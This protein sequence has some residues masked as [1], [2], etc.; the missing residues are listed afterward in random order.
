MAANKSLIRVLAAFVF[1]GAFLLFSMEPMVGR[2]LVPAFGSA[3][4]V[5]S[6]I[7]MWFQ[8]TL[9]L[10]YLYAHYAAT[11]FRKLH[12]V[13]L[14]LP[15]AVLPF[16][17]PETSQEFSIPAMLIALTQHF[18]LPFFVL[19]TTSV[20]AQKWLAATSDEDPYPLYA[21]SNAGSLLALLAY[22]FAVEPFV[23]QQNQSLGWAVAFGVYVALGVGAWHV[24]RPRAASPVVADAN[25]QTKGRT[26]EADPGEEE[27][28]APRLG[29][30]AYW[31]AVAAAP[32]AF[33]LAVT[34]FMVL[35]IGNAPLVWIIPLS[36]YLI[37][38]II[39]FSPKVALPNALRRL[40]PIFALA[41]L[42][43]T[44]NVSGVWPAVVQLG[45][46]FVIA[47]VAHDELFRTRPSATHLT[48]YYLALSFGGWLGSAFVALIAP[49]IFDRLF[50]SHVALIALAVAMAARYRP[51]RMLHRKDVRMIA[52]VTVAFFILVVGLSLVKQKSSILARARSHYGIYVVEAIV[53]EE[54]GE[55]RRLV[56]G[57]TMHGLQIL[58]R[59]EDPLS[60]YH[61]HG[62][63]GDIVA[64]FSPRR[65]GAVGLGV[66][67]IAGY[68]EIEDLTFY[69][70]DPVV[71][72]LARDHFEYLSLDDRE[73]GMVV[74]DARREIAREVAEDAA[75]YEMLII[76]AFSGDAIPT[77]L[78]TREAFELYLARITQEGT[79][80]VH[81]SN[82]YVD[83]GPILS[84]VARDLGLKMVVSDPARETVDDE[85]TAFYVALSRDDAKLAPL[86]ARGWKDAPA[87][88]TTTF[89]DDY[90]SILRAMF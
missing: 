86:R 62:P 61:R 31:A 48:Q 39:A 81:I 56:N 19:G 60:Y 27:R 75:P 87:P 24:S 32:S 25:E 36:L 52:F 58:D 37:T 10:A 29:D 21:A 42:A 50:E 74:G 17:A 80:A 72:Q 41:S 2:L 78:I 14:L 38:F 7:L 84:A 6:T 57:N 5:W 18:A 54:K 22:S 68:R 35:E 15:F 40:W 34:N 12:P 47:W 67:S 73:V 33:S 82:R 65:V 79:L 70:I 45:V 71:V 89:T 49:E 44:D 76:D 26:E 66:G 43:F 51:E 69:E 30:Y 63:L 13:L 1:F 11:T 85:A 8:G 88:Q 4:H 3:F 77:H 9:F 28:R 90:A 64:T 16:A 59:A 20:V 83:L 23:G 55:I 53:T 46:F